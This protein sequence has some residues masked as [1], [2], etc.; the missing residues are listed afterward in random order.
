MD[1]YGLVNIP[2]TKAPMNIDNVV[3]L[4]TVLTPS[5]KNALDPVKHSHPMLV[6]KNLLKKFSI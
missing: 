4:S 6:F 3:Q 1:L 5:I 2:S